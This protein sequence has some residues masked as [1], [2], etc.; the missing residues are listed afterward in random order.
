MIY[1]DVRGIINYKRFFFYREWAINFIN[2]MNNVFLAAM[3]LAISNG[4]NFI[5]AREK[6]V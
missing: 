6:S 4:H 2:K 1:F 3:M 5:Y